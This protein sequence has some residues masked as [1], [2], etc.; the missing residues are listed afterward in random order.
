VAIAGWCIA[1]IETQ[2]ERWANRF[3]WIHREAQIFVARH[4][5]EIVETATALFARGI[6]TLPAEPAQKGIA[7]VD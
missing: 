5:Q 6:T 7:H 3:H 4:Q 2:P 1:G